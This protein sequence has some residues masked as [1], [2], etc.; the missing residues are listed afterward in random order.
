MRVLNKEGRETS[1]PQ[2]KETQMSK[3]NKKTETMIYEVIKETFDLMGKNG[4]LGLRFN[5]EDVPAIRAEMH[6]AC[7]AIRI[8]VESRMLE[9]LHG[10]GDDARQDETNRLTGH[11]DCSCGNTGS[12]IREGWANYKGQP[13]KVM[14][15]IPCPECQ[16]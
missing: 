11:M 8:G 4:L 9:D 15:S 6:Q 1:R 10:L 7:A 3:F 12:V 2:P 16:R 5:D 13:E 14:F